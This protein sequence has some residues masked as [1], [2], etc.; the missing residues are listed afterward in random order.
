MAHIPLI[1]IGSSKDTLL[2]RDK[3]I[4]YKNSNDVLD[5]NL[6][7]KQAHVKQGWGKKYHD[8]IVQKNKLTTR[9][10]IDLLKDEGTEFYEI[11]MF[12]N[13][14]VVF[15]GNLRSPAAGVITGMLHVHGRWCIVIANDNT[16]ASGSWWPNTPEKII[17]AQ[18][19]ALRLH[20]PVIYLVDCSGLFLPEQAR[21]FPGARGAGHIFKKNSELSAYGIPQIAGVFGDCIAGGGYM[22]IIS[23]KVYMTENA[24]M[25]IAGGALIKGAKGQ[26]VTSHSIGNSS[27]HVEIS[28]CADECV[29]DDE[30]LLLAIRKDIHALPTSAIS[31][32]QNKQ[33]PMVPHYDV[34]D[35]AEIVPSDPR[36]AYDA[37]QLLARLCDDSLFWEILP[38]KGQEVICGVGR[39]NGLPVG[40]I[41]NRQGLICD[42]ARQNKKCP[43]GILYRD[44]IAKMSLFS[45]ACNSDGLPIIWFQDI[46]GFDIGPEAERQGLLGYGSN[47]IYT[48]S[49][50]DTPMFTVLL[51]KASGAGYYAMEGMPYDPVIQLSTT[52]A[53]QSVMDGRTLA[54]ATYRTKLDEQ[55]RIKTTDPKERAII[56]EGMKKIEEQIDADMDPYAAASRM[57][58][59]EII[60]IGS[61]RSWLTVFVE[62]SYQSIGHRRIK[63]P[64]IWSLHDIAALWKN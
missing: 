9:T 8:R 18:T 28:G 47:L 39:L 20:V 5:E 1:R 17:R 44:G 57:D 36:I 62:M 32:Y 10:R 64:R 56:E 61:L 21:S 53:R 63:N 33:T 4:Q 43:G 37:M 22:P 48:N 29:S 46:A 42:S 16:V 27:V 24:Y 19:I 51:R 2:H 40:M 12:V 14:G 15:Q 13:D 34:N 52:M 7:K 6:L 41:I 58:T 55:F 60:S 23:D 11:G 3:L 35:L 25:V 54:I 45:R 38:E 26:E 50:N 49:M 59:D 30:A 31:Y